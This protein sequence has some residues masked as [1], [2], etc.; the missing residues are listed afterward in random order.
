[1]L[2]PGPRPTSAQLE[3]HATRFGPEQVAETAAELGLSVTVERPRAPRKVRGPGLR[4]R[5]AKLVAAGHGVEAIA[6]IEDLSPARARRLVEE[7][8]T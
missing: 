2:L 3:R 7:I 4:E 6:E 5:V 8:G 1:M